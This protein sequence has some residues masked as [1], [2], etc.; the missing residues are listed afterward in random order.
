MD[1]QKRAEVALKLL[2][3]SMAADDQDAADFVAS[4]IE[5]Q[6]L[7]AHYSTDAGEPITCMADFVAEMNGDAELIG[8]NPTASV[9]RDSRPLCQM[10]TEERYRARRAMAGR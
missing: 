4:V 7:Y 10:T 1:I 6:R 9:A 2:R 3:V 8:T 5:D